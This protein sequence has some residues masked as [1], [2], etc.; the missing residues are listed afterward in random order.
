MSGRTQLVDAAGNGLRDLAANR[1]AGTELWYM[2]TNGGPS[3]AHL[4]EAGSEGVGIHFMSGLR[5][6][7]EVL[8][9]EV[10]DSN[11]FKLPATNDARIYESSRDY[12][13]PAI[14]VTFYFSAEMTL[15]SG[16]GLLIR[17]SAQNRTTWETA[18]NTHT[19]TATPTVFTSATQTT[20]DGTDGLVLALGHEITGNSGAQHIKVTNIKIFVTE[21]P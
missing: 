10:V 17:M 13:D 16:S 2:K 7:T 9:G 6:W 12:L 8:G 11:E 19:V 20:V 14:G 4:A 5:K 21:A 18:D 15:I 1:T 3:R